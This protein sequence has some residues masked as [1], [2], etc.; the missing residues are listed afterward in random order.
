MCPA[1]QAHTLLLDLDQLV[2][3]ANKLNDCSYSC[4]SSPCSASASDKLLDSSSPKLS[5]AKPPSSPTTMMLMQQQQ[6]PS[7]TTTT[8]NV[9]SPTT[10]YYDKY[11][12]R[13]ANLIDNYK[14]VTSSLDH[15]I[16]KPAFYGNTDAL[17]EIFQHGNECSDNIHN[18]E[19]VFNDREWEKRHFLKTS[20]VNNNNYPS[21]NI[22]KKYRTNHTAINKIDYDFLTFT[23][24][25]YS[26]F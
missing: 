25:D 22:K 17:N 4:S 16:I 18:T 7:P 20:P 5:N 21:T 24:V 2:V 3:K 15:M 19:T 12:D 11:L 10:N 13:F 8:L 9:K 26:K 1:S 23:D 14:N 6:K